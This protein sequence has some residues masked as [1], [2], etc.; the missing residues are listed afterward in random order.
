MIYLLGINHG[1]QFQKE[2]E[3]TKKFLAYLKQKTRDLKIVFI[4][5][6][7]SRDVSRERKVQTTTIEDLARDL[8]VEHQYCDPGEKER[9][10]L[11]IPSIKETE[12][13]LGLS[14][15][16]SSPDAS[17][18]QEEQRK[19]NPIRESYWFDVIR[20]KV[21]SDMIFICGSDHLFTF[22][23]LLV[24]NGCKVKIFSK[25]FD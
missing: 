22:K 18:V 5:E 16:Y 2:S 23:E 20:N 19:F 11:G 8:K 10:Q 24:K 25:S 17:R 15:W 4:V 6:E 21:H 12:G 13:V 9:K 14:R 1:V 7:W 3:Q